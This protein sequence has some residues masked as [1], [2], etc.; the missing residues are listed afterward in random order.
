MEL[1]GGGGGESCNRIPKEKKNEIQK[2]T[3]KWG[4][5]WNTRF[6]AWKCLELQFRV[7]ARSIKSL[8]KT[9]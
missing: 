7:R 5:E 8:L 1:E 4:F 6:G 9:L 3:V 2:I